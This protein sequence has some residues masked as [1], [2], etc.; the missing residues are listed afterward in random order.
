VRFISSTYDQE[1]RLI[2]VTTANGNRSEFSYDGMSRRVETR[3]YQAGSLASTTR[4]L[5]DGLL[6]IAELDTSN[7]VTRT[8]TRGTDLSGSMQ[9]AGG[10]GGILAT[11]GNEYSYDGNGNVRDIIS[12][13]G[14]NVA[15]YEYDPFGNKTASSGSYSSQPY[16]WSSKEFHAPSGM[17]YYLYRFYSPQ[18]GRWINRDPIGEAGGINLY[19][20]V[21]NDGVNFLD[22][23]GLKEVVDVT[24]TKCDEG[25]LGI[26]EIRIDSLGQ[27]VAQQ[28]ATDPAKMKLLKDVINQQATLLE[29]GHAVSVGHTFIYYKYTKGNEEAWGFYPDGQWFGQAGK[30]NDDLN[31][32]YNKHRTYKLCP[33]KIDELKT[34]I[35]KNKILRPIYDIADLQ[36]T[37][38]AVRKLRGIGINDLPAEY[39][40]PF[41]LGEIFNKLPIPLNPKYVHKK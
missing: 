14:L 33:K 11:N 7:A 2:R 24:G 38:W 17:V 13:S 28:I 41:K 3:E 26:V 18:L 8:I 10:I 19:G 37:T 27:S 23:L 22:F 4:Y 30:I 40:E 20:F 9:G 12:A 16:Q 36:D 35:D 15:H 21:G 29:L 1:N 25:C 5:Y 6:P 32:P 34:A 31:S 39:C